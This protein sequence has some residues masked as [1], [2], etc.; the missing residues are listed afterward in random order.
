MVDRT[1]C[2]PPRPQDI[3]RLELSYV[4]QLVS[5][6]APGSRLETMGQSLCEVIVKKMAC[7]QV[8]REC[9]GMADVRYVCVCVLVVVCVYDERQVYWVWLHVHIGDGCM[10]GVC[11]VYVGCSKLHLGVH[12]H[13]PNTF[14]SPPLHS[15]TTLPPLDSQHFPLHSQHLPLNSHTV[16]Q[17][18]QICATATTF[19]VGHT[20]HQWWWIVVI[21]ME[22]SGRLKMMRIVQGITSRYV[23]VGFHVYMVC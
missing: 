11:G 8:F 22:T 14:S 5:Q 18:V 17:C 23:S 6:L 3:P 4:Q 1:L 21:G 10:W 19:T 13:T 7:F 9:H 16:S 15:R 20:W 2:L 12:T